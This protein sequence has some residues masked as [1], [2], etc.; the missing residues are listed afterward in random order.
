VV[1]GH[2]GL[3]FPFWYYI[4]PKKYLAT[5]IESTDKTPNFDAKFSAKLFSPGK[6]LSGSKKKQMRKTNTGKKSF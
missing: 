2:F 6:Q 1:C 5:L 3:F 4:V